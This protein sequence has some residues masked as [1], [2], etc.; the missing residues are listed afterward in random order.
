MPAGGEENQ[1]E[2][3]WDGRDRERERGREGEEK[4][5]SLQDKH[6]GKKKKAS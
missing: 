3:V 4:E 6:R 1:E 5:R 2:R